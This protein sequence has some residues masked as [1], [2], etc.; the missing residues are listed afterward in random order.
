MGC[1]PIYLTGNEI[2]KNTNC[3]VFI[4]EGLSKSVPRLLVSGKH[5]LADKAAVAKTYDSSLISTPPGEFSPLGR[6]RKR[7]DL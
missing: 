2:Y 1:F 5:L 7:M 3:L 6:A 4:P